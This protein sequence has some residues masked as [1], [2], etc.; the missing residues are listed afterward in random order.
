[1]YEFVNK[2]I[3]TTCLNIAMRIIKLETY[4]QPV[5]AVLAVL[6]DITYQKY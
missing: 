6:Q 2:S 4:I 1:M 3:P 5:Q